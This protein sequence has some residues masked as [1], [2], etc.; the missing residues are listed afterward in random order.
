[1]ESRVTRR[2]SLTAVERKAGEVGRRNIRKSDEDVWLEGGLYN[3][4]DGGE[5]K[6]E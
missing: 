1:M 2:R 5:E 3:E 6:K 4:A